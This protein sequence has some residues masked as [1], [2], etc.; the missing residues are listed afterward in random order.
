V[1][2]NNK[3]HTTLLKLP[4]GS[5]DVIYDER[6]YLLSKE[7]KLKGNL[8]KLYAKE[9]GDNDFISL[10]YYTNIGDGLLKPCEMPKEKV[11]NFILK[12]KIN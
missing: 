8:I 5:Y 10:N 3:F 11:I 12:L 1:I 6:R 2:D 9:L 4:N 7:T